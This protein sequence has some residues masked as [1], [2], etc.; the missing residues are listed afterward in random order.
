VHE[1]VPRF[2]LDRIA[3][4]QE[5]GAVQATA[6]YI[7]IAGFTPMT[8]AL[9]R[10]GSHGAEIVAEIL[11][12]AW[13]P[14]VAA[15]HAERGVIATSAGDSLT[16]LF[17]GPGH[18]A[19]GARAGDAIVTA[20]ASPREH[21]TPYG[22]FTIAAKLGLGSGSAA[23]EVVRSRD[24]RRAT[25]LFAGTAIERAVSAEMGAAAGQLIVD[26]SASAG[27]PTAA[28]IQAT[29][30][31]VTLGRARARPIAAP[32]VTPAL[33]DWD[34]P[35]EFR[36]IIPVFVSF[37]AD[38]LQAIVDDV[39]TLQDRFGGLLRPVEVGDKGYVLMIEWGAPIGFEG[40]AERAVMLANELRRRH[41][42]LRIG[43]SYGVA[44][45]GLIGP[46]AHEEFAIV[47]AH[48]N[49]AARLMASA[50]P[51]EL[52]IVPALE[53]RV[54][55][56]FAIRPRGTRT[57]RGIAA[58]VELSAVLGEA[59]VARGPQ[60]HVQTRDHVGRQHELAVLKDALAS[61]A[62][63]T[64]AGAIVVSGEPGIGK[65][66]LVA[67]ARAQL[68]DPRWVST[69]AD[70]VWRQALQPMR[71]AA[72]ELLE[73]STHAPRA[74]NEQRFDAVI[75]R[76]SLIGDR[77]FLG[78]LVD[79]FWPDSDWERAEA[80]QRQRRTL[81]A[82]TAL[83][84]AA[85][86][87]GRGLVLEV[88]DMQWA[89]LETRA[90]LP[91]L[92]TSLADVPFVLLMTTRP[93]ARGQGNA[94]DAL[95]M[96]G[97]HPR[98]EIALGPLSA[99]DLGALAAHRLGRPLAPETQA[100]LSERTAGNP[101]FAEQL[102]QHLQERSALHDSAA[103]VTTNFNELEVPPSVEEVVVAR[104]DD[105]PGPTR[106]VVLIASVLGARPDRGELETML[107]NAGARDALADA[108]PTAVRGGFWSDEAT[109]LEFAHAL[110][111][112][113]AYG[114][115]LVAT[116]R[117][118][119]A[120]A[121][122]AIEQRHGE[123]LGP[124]LHRL[125]GHHAE[126]EQ[127]DHAI[128]REREAADRALGLG[129]YRE[130][131]EYAAAGL[132]LAQRVD[133]NQAPG[134]S[135]L[136]LWL[137]LGGA[138]IVTHGQASPETKDAYD[139]ASALSRTATQTRDGFR[140]L[141]GLRTYHLFAGEHD[142]SLVMAERSLQVAE[143]I[144]DE[145]LLVQAHLMVGNARFWVGDLDA[146]EHHLGE[147]FRRLP[148]GHDE[149][150]FAAFAQSPRFTALFPAAMTRSLRGDADG[151]LALATDGLRDAR[152]LG[153]RFS[154][155]MVLQVLGFLHCRDERPRG[156]L[157][158]GEELAALADRE[159]FPV[160]AA[161]GALVIGWGKARLGDT[162]AGLELIATTV[163]RMQATGAMV[164]TTL[165]GALTADAQLAAGHADAA[166]RTAETALADAQRRRELA[167][168]PDLERLRTRALQSQAATPARTTSER[169]T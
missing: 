93:D 146:A 132:A 90:Y 60:P 121:A 139:R 41:R 58:P 145:D 149:Q 85:A 74:V 64:G 169:R 52:L 4:G 79:L 77:A 129:A 35:G 113:A 67:A 80:A 36:S 147:M 108:V 98:T 99:D 18:Q 3:A 127:F 125:A 13:N 156:A 53:A 166:R 163:I 5:Q 24:K 117:R 133:G 7:D 86:T 131:G 103:G 128:G 2:L 17:P 140:A 26:P 153:H 168:V 47:G 115:L 49:L 39:F 122:A 25:Y 46:P 157:E 31:A 130:A 155:A 138:R 109:H 148:P 143:A 43:A 110:V 44:F 84:R 70:P 101:F 71:G 9:S 124:H 95:H 135:E 102:V 27:R 22:T 158:L 134:G 88:E 111:R 164:A 28:A 142:T 91:E 33:L 63:G 56:R 151:A 112:D 1:L 65:S 160:Y 61:V 150:H 154:E 81:V 123:R 8:A 62:E 126:A 55:A 161:I 21:P 51:D 114:T 73:Q 19:R 137:A 6:L 167:F 89:D 29:G 152:A 10:H 78:A 57:L 118:L 87:D 116:R 144:G 12:G 69:A 100:W 68:P 105:L 20:V 15:V 106:R 14:I 16:A 75:D 107:A 59:S 76:Y 48:I 83:L 165:I 11:D 97:G 96:T 104:L 42:T 92:A 162:A 94:V 50:A 30:S 23:W 82:L 119:H 120:E 32:F 37:P 38:Q 45:T 34:G 40:D 66:S 72:R 141:F 136:G 54:G 159:G